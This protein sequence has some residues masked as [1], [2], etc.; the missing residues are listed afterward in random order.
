MCTRFYVQPTT[1]PSIIKK[2]RRTALAEQF[3]VKL[4]KP[5]DMTG[6]I[7]PMDLA[8]VIA[9][10]KKGGIAAFP[11]MW[12]FHVPQY[13]APIVNTRLE[14]APEKPL[15]SD[16]WLHRRCVIPASWYYEWERIRMSNGKEKAG[17]KYMIQ[18]KGAE[19][20]WLA[21]LYRFEEYQGIQVPV[22]SVVTMPSSSSVRQLHDRMPLIL[23]ETCV[24]EWVSSKGNPA[25]LAK[26][27][28]SDMII[29]RAV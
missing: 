6:D 24:I 27:A 19:S 12:G 22:F 11:M 16:S 3:L 8:A 10:D 13:T 26:Y 15:W 20:I 25:R 2:A 9:P 4:A 14:T 21:G 23:P 17:T 5:T 28:K 29:E 18:P 1:A 7:R